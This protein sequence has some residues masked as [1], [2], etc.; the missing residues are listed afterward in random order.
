MKNLIEEE[1]LIK[2]QSMIVAFFGENKMQI[3]ITNTEFHFRLKMKYFGVEGVITKND[4]DAFFVMYI[5]GEKKDQSDN[6]WGLFGMLVSTLFMSAFT[7]AH[8]LLKNTSIETIEKMNE[9]ESK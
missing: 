2:M 8:Q 3:D 7:A 9:N 6:L 1:I 5:Q 4:M